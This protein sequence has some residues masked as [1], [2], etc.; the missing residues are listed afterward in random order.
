M[1]KTYEYWS[2]QGFRGSKR[3]R[4]GRVGEGFDGQAQSSQPPVEQASL[5]S[6]VSGAYSL[7]ILTLRTR[8]QTNS[9]LSSILPFRFPPLQKET[10]TDVSPVSRMPSTRERSAVQNQPCDLRPRSRPPSAACGPVRVT[11]LASGSLH[12]S[13]RPARLRRSVCRT[14]REVLCTQDT[15]ASERRIT[16]VA[17]PTPCTPRW[18]G[19][20]GRGRR[21][22]IATRV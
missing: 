22:L 2:Y 11:R 1:P 19:T 3:P 6:V 7:V 13:M 10:W 16:L 21:S 8:R 5:Q 18:P 17:P 4:V 9:T 12:M 20:P 14:A 15:P